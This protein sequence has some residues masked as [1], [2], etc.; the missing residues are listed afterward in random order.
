MPFQVETIGEWSTTQLIKFLEDYARNN[1][2][3]AIAQ[4]KIE[5]LEVPALLH[6]QDQ[7]QFDNTQTN[8][9]A[10]G[11]ATALPA[12]PSGYIRVLDSTGLPFV[13]PYYKAS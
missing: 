3:N 6:V 4:Q 1:P 12:T 2:A 10:A 9:G 5:T 13:V 8:V 7:I 11:S